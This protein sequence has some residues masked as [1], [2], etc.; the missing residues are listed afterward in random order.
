MAHRFPGLEPQTAPLLPEPETLPETDAVWMAR[1]RAA[2]SELAAAREAVALADAQARIDKAEERPDPSVALRVGRARNGGEQVLGVSI[3]VPFGGDARD[4][5]ARAGAARATAARRQQDEALRL[6]EALA[7]Q[8]L[9]ASRAAHASWL[10]QAE[11]ARRMRTA[12]DGVAR[13]FQLG[14]GSLADVLAARRMA[15]E[16]ELEAGL[17]AVD[18]WLL[19]S[20]LELEAGQLWAHAPRPDA[21]GG[22]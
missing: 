22:P 17:A 10:R 20:R 18:A 13:S 11:A 4:A 2:N 15:N 6:S 14:E 21:S 19:R 7:A 9:S 5:A 16:Q 12:A 8:Q 1:L 3:N